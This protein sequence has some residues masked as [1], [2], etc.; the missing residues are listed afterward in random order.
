[1]MDGGARPVLAVVCR[2]CLPACLLELDDN[3]TI[4]MTT[5]STIVILSLLSLCSSSRLRTAPSKKLGEK[6]GSLIRDA[7]QQMSADMRRGEGEPTAFQASI[8]G[9]I[10]SSHEGVWLV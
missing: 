1:M 8:M 5:F 6:V 10:D 3:R 9:R 7:N 4:K 2:C